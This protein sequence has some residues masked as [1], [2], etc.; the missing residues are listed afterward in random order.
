MILRP[1]QERPGRVARH[2]PDRVEHLRLGTR[3]LALRALQ[4]RLRHRLGVPA[5]EQRT[6]PGR[7]HLLE[8]QPPAEHLAELLRLLHRAEGLRPRQDVRLV[9]VALPGEGAHGH[10]GDVTRVHAGVGRPSV[11][12]AHDVLAAH[13]SGPRQGVGHE[14]AGAQQC[15]AEPRGGQGR[16]AVPLPAGD[17]VLRPGVG[18]GGRG[19]LHHLPH[20]GLAGGAEEDLVVVPRHPGGDQQGPLHTVER[21]PQSGR[22]PVVRAHHRDV[23]MRAGDPGG[24]SGQHA[25]RVVAEEPVEHQPPHRAG[26][27]R[28][29]NHLSP[30]GANR[31]RTGCPVIIF[32]RRKSP[33]GQPCGAARCKIQT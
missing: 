9:R 8:A 13:G 32:V 10:V 12:R 7:F 19:Q 11:Q 23:R 24:V 31:P 22:V 16:L 29:K 28:H 15:P 33:R 21:L 1:G 4:Q 18:D 30:S 17:E 27:S 5:Q 14:G 6:R 2:H 3:P 26:G 20:P 25:H